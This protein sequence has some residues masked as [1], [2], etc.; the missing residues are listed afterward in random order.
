MDVIAIDTPQLGN[1]SYLLHDAGEVLVVDPVRD[2]E[3]RSRSTVGSRAGSL[4]ARS[5]AAS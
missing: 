3:R 4:S 5:S 2:V 1:R